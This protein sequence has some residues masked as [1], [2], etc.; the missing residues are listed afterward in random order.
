MVFTSWSLH[1]QK[2]LHLTITK[3]RF[4]YILLQ[5]VVDANWKF[6]DYD[7][8]LVGRNH[9][10]ALFQKTDIGKKTMEGAFTFIQMMW[11]LET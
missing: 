5:E 7:F 3:K 4:Y 6:W 8:K 9:D 11:N 2:T 10:C 1:L